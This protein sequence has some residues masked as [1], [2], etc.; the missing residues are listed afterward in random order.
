MFAR[1][2]YTAFDR[3]CNNDGKG[4]FLRRIPCKKGEICEDEDSPKNLIYGSQFTYVISNVNQPRFWYISIVA[5]YRNETTCEW[6]YFDY[7]R[8]LPKN[9]TRE[10]PTLHYSMN[11]VNGHPNKEQSFYSPFI[12]QF[13]FD[14]QNILEQFIIFF[15]V[16]LVLVP[17]QIHGVRKQN[18]PL[19]KLFTFSLILEFISTLF[20]LI[21]LTKFSV[22]G[23]GNESLKVAGDI[24]DILSRVSFS[25]D[26]L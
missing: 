3:K 17:I 13:S 10:V 4:D 15:V 1:L 9:S 22:N 23:I 12:Y 14:Q 11:L 21:H 24:F 8:H 20:I 19:T 18:H 2:N 7:K 6:E 5:C 26:I 16:Y 25:K